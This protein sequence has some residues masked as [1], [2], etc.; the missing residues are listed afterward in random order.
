M[1]I[2]L[3]RCID[4]SST[5]LQLLSPPDG[6]KTGRVY[7]VAG[8]RV[9]A[10][11]CCWMQE[12]VSKLKCFY[13]LFLSDSHFLRVSSFLTLHE[14]ENIHSFL[15]FWFFFVFQRNRN[16]AKYKC[17]GVVLLLYHLS[18]TATGCT[19]YSQLETSVV[20]FSQRDTQ[21]T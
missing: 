17:V 20:D 15:F 18:L 19:S 11:S 6:L 7:R 21:E 1:F 9:L 13:W 3:L 4:G 2:P 10:F 12:T 16:V 5:T 8:R 14:K